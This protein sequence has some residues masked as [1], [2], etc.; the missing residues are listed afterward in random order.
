M[1]GRCLCS[2]R[3]RQSSAEERK[4]TWKL[5]KYL[6]FHSEIIATVL[7]SFVKQHVLPLCF[8]FCGAVFQGK[9]IFAP[10]KSRLFVKKIIKNKNIV[11]FYILFLSHLLFYLRKGQKVLYQ[12][13]CCST[14]LVLTSCNSFYCIFNPACLPLWICAVERH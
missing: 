13:C 1:Q 12:C 10:L 11:M 4:S 7:F 6:I 3:K 5:F 8:D 14:K 2:L 9:L